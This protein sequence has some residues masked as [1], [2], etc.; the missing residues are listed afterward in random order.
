MKTYAVG[1]VLL[2]ASAAAE[3]QMNIQTTPSLAGATGE[4]AGFRIGPRYSNYSTDVDIEIVTIDSGRQHAFGL[5]GDMRSG[6]FV[7][8]FNVDHDPENGLQISDLLP[9]EFGRYERTRGEFTVGWAA[10]PVIDLQAGFRM[11]TFSIGGQAFGGS[12]FGGEDFD[13]S[14]ILG[15]I[16]VHTPTRHPFGVYG[17]FRGYVGS[18]DFGGSAFQAQVD[19]SGW[20]AEGGVEIPIGDSRWHAVPGIEFERLTAEPRVVVETNRFFVNFVYTFPR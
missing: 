9:I 17:L 18:I 5:A 14:A 20:R 15:G 16:H 3:A 12:L 2:L 13:H 19:S 6:S 4:R 8:D 7:L 1:L 11:D 10:M